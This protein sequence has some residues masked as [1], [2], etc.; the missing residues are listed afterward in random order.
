MTDHHAGP[1][2]GGDRDPGATATTEYRLAHL[3]ERLAREGSGDMGI[4]LEMRGG[5]LLLTGTV[6]SA[7]NREEILR[8]VAEVLPDVPVRSDI[9]LTDHSAPGR[10]EELS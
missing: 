10:P 5:S 9:G 4:R 7:A 3:Q 6:P 1:A 2:A 8:I